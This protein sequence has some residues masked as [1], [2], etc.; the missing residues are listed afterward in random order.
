MLWGIHPID[1]PI[2]PTYFELMTDTKCPETPNKRNQMKIYLCLAL[3]LFIAGCGALASMSLT[4]ANLDK[5]HNDMSPAEVKAILGDPADS[6]T[7]AIPIVGGTQTTYTYHSGSS[8]VTI[9]FKNDLM[10]EKNGTFGQ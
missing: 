1:A 10:K 4:Q 9:I 2:I 6:K 7:E 8:D 5:I 3:T